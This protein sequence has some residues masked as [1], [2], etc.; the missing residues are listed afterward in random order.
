MSDLLRQPMQLVE[1]II[2][3]IRASVFFSFRRFQD[4]L[5]EF[6]LISFQLL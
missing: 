3:L 4:A 6:R 5:S 2:L 1:W